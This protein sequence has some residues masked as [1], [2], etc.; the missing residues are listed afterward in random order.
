M[1]VSTG[2]SAGAVLVRR[3]AP[4][5]RLTSEGTLRRWAGVVGVMHC[6]GALAGV[7]G[8]GTCAP[9]RP[10]RS[11]LRARRRRQVARSRWA[12]GK[13][14]RKRPGPSRIRDS[15]GPA[16]L[17]MALVAP[18][19]RVASLGTRR[20]RDAAHAACGALQHC[21]CRFAGTRLQRTPV[22]SRA[23]AAARAASVAVAAAAGA[24]RAA[25]A[26][27]AVPAAA[28][29]ESCARES[30]PWWRSRRAHGAPPL[31]AARRGWARLGMGRWWT[32]EGSGCKGE[33]THVSCCICR[34]RTPQVSPCRLVRT[35]S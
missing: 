22:G 13:G 9:S 32:H 31:P 16:G 1:T 34:R 6:R 4:E 21:A 11:L 2:L 27:A 8:R 33:H 19:A 30:N 5:M 14:L 7:A 24:A 3:A 18:P 26:A 23:A 35:R 29:V 15:A 20:G 12:R 25:A 17:A 10:Q 28:A